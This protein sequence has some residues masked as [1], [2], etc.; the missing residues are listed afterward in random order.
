NGLRKLLSRSVNR[1]ER[2][3]LDRTRVR[4]L[5][6][7]AI[8]HL[9]TAIEHICGRVLPQYFT[10]LDGSRVALLLQTAIEHLKHVGCVTHKEIYSVPLHGHCT[11]Q[12]GN[13]PA[14]SPL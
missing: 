2:F 4:L 1:W 3:L 11:Q 6:W 7:A 14:T 10:S 8:E 5:L 13:Y 9:W 12:G